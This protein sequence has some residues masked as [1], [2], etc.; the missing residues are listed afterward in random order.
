M[1]PPYS[2]P[3]KGFL[4]PLLGYCNL[5]S[6]AGSGRAL[7]WGEP[8]DLSILGLF[9]HYPSRVTMLR[10]PSFLTVSSSGF[11][12]KTLVFLRACE[13]RCR[14]A[15]VAAGLGLPLPGGFRASTSSVHLVIAGLMEVK[16][17]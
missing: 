17:L 9:V 7:G 11:C 2:C 1:L 4:C 3:C 10:F 12:W 14:A 16:V 5:Q 15:A 8:A 6:P 13:M